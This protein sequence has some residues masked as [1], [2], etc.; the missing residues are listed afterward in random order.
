MI[1]KFK[2]RRACFHSFNYKLEPDMLAFSGC[3]IGGG[4]KERY[5]LREIRK[6]WET[7][8]DIDAVGERR[9]G[10]CPLT[11]HEVGLMLSALGFENDAYIYVAS[12]EIYGGE[13]TLEPLKDLFP[14]LYTKEILANEDRKPFLPFSSCLAAIDYIV[15][16]E[17]DVFAPIIMEIWPRF[18]QVEGEK[19]ELF[20]SC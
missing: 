14:N 7:L 1:L 10:K 19:S 12:G 2:L 18:L 4:D 8:P 20:L 6:R 15:C 5:E 16:D 11:P 13:E 3:Y 17:S 9:R